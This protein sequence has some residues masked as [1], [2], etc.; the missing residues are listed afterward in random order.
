MLLCNLEL[1]STALFWFSLIGSDYLLLVWRN[2]CIEGTMVILGKNL[3]KLNM[4]WKTSHFR[5]IFILLFQSPWTSPWHMV[6]LINQQRC[7]LW[8][9]HAG[10]FSF[11]SA[12]QSWMSQQ[13]LPPSWASFLARRNSAC[14]STCVGIFLHPCSKLCTALSEI[15]RSWAISFWDFP[16]R[17]RILESSFLSIC[18]LQCVLSYHTTLW[19]NVKFFVASPWRPWWISFFC[20]SK[21]QFLVF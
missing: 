1:S 10:Q 15:A 7:P 8:N 5:H 12:G 3:Q 4:E 11:I 19:W 20:K 14:L 6:P 13:G 17:W 18:F 21:G 9:S 2:L 16:S